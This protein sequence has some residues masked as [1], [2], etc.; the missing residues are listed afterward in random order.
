MENKENF[1]KF[2][3]MARR[4]G[5]VPNSSRGEETYEQ[6]TKKEVLRYV[7]MI[8]S[9]VEFYKYLKEKKGREELRSIW[10]LE[11]A[12][13]CLLHLELRIG[14]NILTSMCQEIMNRVK[15]LSLLLL[16]LL[17]TSNYNNYYF[18]CAFHS[19]STTSME[20]NMEGIRYKSLPL[21]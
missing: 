10:K 5:R 17:T 7:M 15:F 19:T 2:L 4:D 20:T 21:Q 9:K 8:A 12:V 18:Y 16:L 14:E 13:P 6:N 3:D 11:M 1:K